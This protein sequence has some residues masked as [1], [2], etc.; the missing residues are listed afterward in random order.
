MVVI[1][2][3]GVG[4]IVVWFVVDVYVKVLFMDVVL[5]GYEGGNICYFV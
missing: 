5:N 1:G 2:F 3:G 4:V